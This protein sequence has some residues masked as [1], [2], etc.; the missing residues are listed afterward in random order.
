M[1][2]IFWLSWIA[3]K[4]PNFDMGDTTGDLPVTIILVATALFWG[5]AVFILMQVRKSRK[6]PPVDFI[7]VISK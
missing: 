3:S 4:I 6:H 5:C 1:T 7:S 2:V